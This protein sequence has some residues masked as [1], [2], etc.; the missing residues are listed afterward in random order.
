MG[1][2]FAEDMYVSP[3]IVELSKNSF[4]A[5]I[6]TPSIKKPYNPW[7]YDM[8]YGAGGSFYN[9]I[10]PYSIPKGIHLTLECLELN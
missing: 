10:L 8:I 7:S 4:S 1:Y 9:T 6:F 2:T 3:W 5:S